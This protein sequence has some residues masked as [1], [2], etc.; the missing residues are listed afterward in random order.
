M[1][2]ADIVI[3]GAGAAGLMAARELSKTQSN[4][5]IIEAAAFAGGRIRAITGKGFTIPVEGGAEFV[6][7][8]LPF[9]IQLLK[10]AGIGFKAVEGKI[11]Q[12]KNGALKQQEDFM[13]GNED[14]YKPLQQLGVDMTVK[15]F[16]D[17]YFSDSAHAEMRTSVTRF[18]EGYEAADITRASVLAMRGDLIHDDEEQYRIEG[19]YNKLVEYLY[20][21]CI[22][23]GCTFH[24]SE[25]VKQI[26]WEPGSAIIKTDI[27]SYRA[28]KVLIT[29]PIGIL[30]QELNQQTAIQFR[31]AITNKYTAAKILG[32][33]NVIK[34]LLEFDTHFWPENMGF[35]FS[36]EAIPTWWTQL[37][38]KSNLLT[39]WLGGPK[40]EQYKNI[41]DGIILEAALTSLSNMFN[42]PAD[43]LNMQLKA[44]H[45]ANWQQEPFIQCAYTY[46]TV[47]SESAKE[48]LKQP[49]ANTVFFAGEAIY[50]GTA[51]GTVEAALTSAVNVVR[52]ILNS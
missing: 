49:E 44:W 46:A 16:L 37:P 34:V 43:T 27:G 40:T 31:P 4:I 1:K 14:M 5:L 41:A 3:V 45:V 48:V 13:I 51:A 30:Q 42:L 21:Q 32:S 10:E 29:V 23:N 17:Q 22:S 6:H 19:G 50:T 35:L 36:D 15:D 12:H 9:T 25:I 18:I 24:L 28:K 33:G 38:D 47:G 7:G 26:T 2:E 52:D 20:T 39:G 11:M 8:N